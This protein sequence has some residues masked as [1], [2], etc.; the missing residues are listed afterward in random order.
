MVSWGEPVP[1]PLLFTLTH[2]SLALPAALTSL[3]L[4]T[5]IPSLALPAA[6]TSRLA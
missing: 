1:T 4:P 3:A 2:P 5:T 6:L